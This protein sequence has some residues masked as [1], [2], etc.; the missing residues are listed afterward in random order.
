[1]SSARPTPVQPR[2]HWLRWLLVC[3]LLGAAGFAA[4]TCAGIVVQSER[5]ES[6]PADAIVV[7]GAAEYSGRPLPVFRA[8]LDHAYDL[9]KRHMA[10]Y[11]IVTGGAGGDPKFSEGG[12]GRKYLMERGVPADQIIAETQ[13]DNTLESAER[14]AVIMKANRLR[15]CDA[16]SDGYHMFRLKKM[17]GREGI[18][19]Y[20]AP[21]PELHPPDRWHRAQLVLR[22]FVSYSLWRVHLA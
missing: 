5:D 3:V 22:E 1:M 14:I 7:F 6:R 17:L 21:R 15:T 10:P 19:A 13:G 8:R 16:V 2:P 11:V 20:A 9:Y 18:E 12:V 4:V